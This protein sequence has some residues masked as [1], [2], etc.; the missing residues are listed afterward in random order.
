MRNHSRLVRPPRAIQ[1]A[2]RDNLALVPGSLFPFLANCQRMANRLPR[3][4][5]LI[6]LPPDNPS[7]KRT[8]LTVARF[9]AQE[10]HQVRVMPAAELEHPSAS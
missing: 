7:Q 4:G 6:A 2:H 8:L 9:L 1:Q 3:G 5:V 10:G